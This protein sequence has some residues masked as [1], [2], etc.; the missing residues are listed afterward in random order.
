MERD[1]NRDIS[2]VAI[3]KWYSK[4][5]KINDGFKYVVERLGLLVSFVTAG[6]VNFRAQSECV[7]CYYAFLK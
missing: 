4:I 5:S 6:N 1:F 7:P 3:G 2:T